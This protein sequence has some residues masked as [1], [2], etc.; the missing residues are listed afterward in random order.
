[1]SAGREP[2]RLDLTVISGILVTGRMIDSRTGKPAR[3]GWLR[4]TLPGSPNVSL[5]SA[6][7][8]KEGEF[9]LRLPPGEYEV[10]TYEW[11][12]GTYRDRT[13][14]LDLEE[15]T[16]RR[17][18][19]LRYTERPGL[20]GR[21]VDRQGKPVKG[22]IMLGGGDP[23]DTS[24]EGAF[25]IPEPRTEGQPEGW[26][27]GWATSENRKLARS[28]YWH[29]RERGKELEITL[30]PLSRVKGKLVNEAGEPVPKAEFDLWFN[31]PERDRSW[32]SP[33]GGPWTTMLKSDGEFTVERMPA[34]VSMQMEIETKGH[35]TTVALGQIEPGETRNLGEVVLKPNRGRGEEGATVPAAK[36]WN[37][38]ISGTVVNQE[39]EPVTGATVRARVFGERFQDS[40]DLKGHFRL[41][42]LPA[43]HTVD[44]TVSN[45]DGY[46]H[47]NFEGIETGSED[48]QLQIFPPAYRWH[49]KQAPKLF[50]KRWLNSEPLTLEELRGKVVLLQVGAD[51]TRPRAMHM[52]QVVEAAT[53]YKDRAFQVI[54][55]VQNRSDFGQE[56]MTEERISN[57]IE[58]HRINFPLAEDGDPRRVPEKDL[59]VKVVNGATYSVYGRGMFLIDKKGILR[60]SPTRQNLDERIKKLL[61][62]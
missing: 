18:L 30:K 42:E 56:G 61:V 58:T 3:D 60:C 43:D 41:E 26:A 32:S 21:L 39:D 22:K 27:V 38:T 51:I 37:A 4:V 19:T 57:F 9:E 34:G 54:G 45:A 47:G 6:Q 1:M 20:D 10:R 52:D 50:V 13:W 16:D 44:L 49:G 48:V 59:N 14:P 12:D 24:V 2:T 7:A 40:T 8:N 28:L 55:V 5:N 35:A 53:R 46:R 36:D 11:H 17:E 31:Q 62:E 33:G 25:S 23:V 15:G 29:R